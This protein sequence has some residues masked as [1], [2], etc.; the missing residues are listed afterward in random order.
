[1]PQVASRK[2]NTQTIIT[3][4]GGVAGVVFLIVIILA[5]YLAWRRWGHTR[6][7]TD[8]DPGDKAYHRYSEIDHTTVSFY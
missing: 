7:P 8:A 2:L 6:T 4:L 5:L 1:M 3:A